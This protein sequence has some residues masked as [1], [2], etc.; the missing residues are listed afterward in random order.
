LLRRYVS[1]LAGLLG[2]AA[3]FGG[4]GLACGHPCT[5]LG[6]CSGFAAAKWHFVQ[7]A[8]RAD[9]TRPAVGGWPLSSLLEFKIGPQYITF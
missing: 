1:G 9:L 8:L 3:A 6:P 4:L 7:T 2:P 5:A